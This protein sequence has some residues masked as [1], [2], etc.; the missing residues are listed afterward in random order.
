M[1]DIFLPE[2]L[3]INIKN[4]TLYPNGLDFTYDFV[5]G[6]NLVIGGNG[7]GKTTFVSLIKYALI[8]NYKK[9]YEYTKTYRENKIEK[10]ERNSDDFFKNR[11]DKSIAVNTPP[12]VTI[13]FKVND[14]IFTV[15]RDLEEIKIESLFID[16]IEIIG[17]NITEVKY[18]AL[19]KKKAV[20]HEL[21]EYLPFI[22][23]KE[24][25]KIAKISFDDLIF[26]VN[27]I[28]FFGEDHR[29]VLWDDDVQK[30]LFNTF[31]NSPE[32]NLERQE[33]EREAKYFDSR[34]RHK[35]EDKRAINK[36][37]EKIQKKK[38]DNEQIK[39][40]ITEIIRI[41]ANI[42]HLNLETINVHNS[43]REN[44][45]RIAILESDKNSTAQRLDEIETQRN[46]LIHTLSYSEYKSQHRLYNSFLK[47]IQTNH[48]C[49]I[50]NSQSEELYL[51]TVEN[52]DKCWVCE[53]DIINISQINNDSKELLKNITDEFNRASVLLKN[54]QNEI[55]LLEQKNKELDLK[56]RQLDSE[57]RLEQ[58]KLREHE[59]E[60]NQNE[61]PSELQAFYEEIEKLTQE[62]EEFSIKSEERKN[63]ANEIAQLIEDTVLK[64]VQKFSN[65]FSLY[66]YKFLG[67]D[68]KLTYEKLDNDELKKFYPKIN[69]TIRRSEFELSESQ[70]FFIDHSFRMS[71]LSH[72]Y[73]TPTFY[74][75]ETPDSSLDLSYEKNAADVF[76]SFLDKP[77]NLILTS[78]LNNS[79]FIN[80]ILENNVNELSIVPLFEIAR[81]SAIQEN[82]DILNELYNTIKN[83]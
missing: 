71:I 45:S 8:G 1:R 76:S 22:Y 54:I 44:F 51:K 18:E 55:K 38:V 23:E 74:I 17:E 19:K 39:D 60:N 43:R 12:S 34:A 46:Q 7:M 56:F 27:Y 35:S 68:C 15:V 32:L 16:G 10:R 3:S 70:R 65:Q 20:E 4:Y 66:A 30:E 77:Y 64:N 50:C 2:L 40:S 79:S 5:K 41:K 28:L 6:F 61:S 72:F 33:A 25:E 75:V 80:F 26:F 83:G 36:V 37:L 24:F 42:E 81:K 73:T 29:T 9:Q 52:Q 63:K 82:S 53:S 62:Q 21:E 67:V 48:I 69:G 57:K 13:N 31:F 58:V 14:T 78:N 49:P 11:I 59:F 47:N